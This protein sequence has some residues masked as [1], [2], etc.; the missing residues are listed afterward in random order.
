M[1]SSRSK[2]LDIFVAKQVK[3]SVS[4]P[5]SSNVYLT[6]GRAATWAN[7]AAPP[8][9]NSSAINTNEIWKNMIGGKRITGN[10]IRHAIPRINWTSGVVYDPYDD[11]IDSLELYNSSYNFYV[12]TSEHNVF[13]CLSNNNGAPSTVMPNILVTTTHFQTADGYT[14]KY[15]YSLTAEEKLR[16]LTPSFI[17]VKTLAQSDNSQQW[18]VQE[19]AIDGAIH[20]IN[21]TNA[22]SGYTANDVVVS[23]TGDG[24]YANAFAVLNTS[25]NT[26]QSIVIDNLGYGYTYANVTL[27]STTGAGASARAIIS[28]QGGHGSDPITELGGSYL[29]MDVQIKDTESGVLTTHNDYRQISLIEDPRLYGVTTMSSLPAFSQLTV[30]SLNGTSVEYVEDEVVY[31]GASL[32]SS[33]FRGHVVEWDSGNNIIKLSNT[34]GIPSK[35]LLIGANTTAAR[36]VSAITNPTLQ[37]RSGNLLYTDNMT[38]IQRADDQA[39]DYK[40]VLNF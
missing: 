6:F 1:S 18:I 35:D 33:F 24:F 32:A 16:F 2:N 20:V 40:I 15:M 23:I 4:E 10:N 13:K 38:A 11:L 27:G 3:E 26:V 19:N 30:L 14:W 21:V 39:E 8:Q 29:I 7:D 17:P 37:P 28:P 34:N 25:S 5:S 36:F 31:Q 22:G 9:A 12:M